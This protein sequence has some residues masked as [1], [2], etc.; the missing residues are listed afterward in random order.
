VR[1]EKARKT[2]NHPSVP[3]KDDRYNIVKQPGDHNTLKISFLNHWD[4]GG[5]PAFKC[6]AKDPGDELSRKSSME[7][8]KSSM[9]ERKS[10][11]EEKKEEEGNYMM[12]NGLCTYFV[13]PRLCLST[14]RRGRRSREAVNNLRRIRKEQCS[15]PRLL[16]TS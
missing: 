5:K 1:I 11:M 3:Q 9:E 10:S 8:R 12:E 16:R 2:R 6:N 4:S 13:Y 14:C 7:E 15:H